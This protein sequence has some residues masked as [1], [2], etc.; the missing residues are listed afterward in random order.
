MRGELYIL[1]ILPPM[2]ACLKISSFEVPSLLVPGDSAYLTCLFDLGGEKLYSVKW[3]KDDQEFYRFFPSLNPQYMAFRAPGIHV[4][5]SKSG[6]STVYLTNV[7][8]ETEGRF[9]CQVS[10]DEPFFGCVQVHRNISV[11]IPPEESPEITGEFTDYGENLTLRCLSARSKPA[12][13]LS[14]Y[15]NDVMMVPEG[16][17]LSH[18]IVRH[19]DKLESSSAKLWYQRVQSYLMRLFVTTTSW[20]LLQP[21]CLNANQMVPEGAV[22]SHEIVRHHDKLESSSAKL[23][24]PMDSSSLPEGVLRLACEAS[25]SNFVT[26]ISKELLISREHNDQPPQHHIDP[27][28]EVNSQADLRALGFLLVVTMILWIELAGSG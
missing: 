8:L 25:I 28:E 16:A 13:N 21:N 12:A 14:W 15:I 20:N 2:I 18:E 4:D 5:L 24:I 3:F 27:Q 1:L 9:T 7:T 11:Y 10:A 22:L 26:S 23:D 6:R 19:H 17:V